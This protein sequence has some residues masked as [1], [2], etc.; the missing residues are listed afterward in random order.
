MAGKDV[1]KVD[2]GFYNAVNHDRVYQAEEFNRI[3]EGIIADGIFSTIGRA[4][5]VEPRGG[6]LEITIGT[7]RAWFDSTWTNADT[8]K[9]LEIPEPAPI[10]PRIDLVVLEIN[11][12]ERQNYFKIV[13][14][15]P[16]DEPKPPALVKSEYITQYALAQI[17]VGKGS[18]Y[19]SVKPEDITDLRGTEDTP[20][21]SGILQQLT[22]EELLAKWNLQIDET[23]ELLTADEK[24]WMD[25]TKDDVLAWYADLKVIISD[26]LAIKLREEMTEVK[27]HCD[28]KVDELEAY[29]K[30]IVWAEEEEY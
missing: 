3:F 28:T 20:Y 12:D 30:G 26:D 19:T 21:S 24:A 18:E 27:N 13:T 5:V 10:L 17:N 11:K 4:F 14:G 1:T 15:D 7:G 6:N 25:Q 22:I 2:S 9:I 16:D 8:I 29:V 23:K